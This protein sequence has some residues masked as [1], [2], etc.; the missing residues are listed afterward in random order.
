MYTRSCTRPKGRSGT[1][2]FQ[3]RLANGVVRKPD[4]KRREREAT[5]QDAGEVTPKEEKQTTKEE[6]HPSP[7]PG[8]EAG[9]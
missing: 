1:N 2:S 8:E 5:N 6:E 3:I 4:A 9:P 7:P